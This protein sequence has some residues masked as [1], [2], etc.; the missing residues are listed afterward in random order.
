VVLRELMYS[1]ECDGITQFLS[2]WLGKPP[3]SMSRKKTKG[4]TNDWTMK[5]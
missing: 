3:G 2:P 1:H 5:K 4:V